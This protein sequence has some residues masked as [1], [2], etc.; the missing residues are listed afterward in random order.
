M[1]VAADR[2][3]HV[4]FVTTPLVRGIIRHPERL[5]L[6]ADRQE[7]LYP[8]VHLAFARKVAGHITS[9]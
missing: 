4:P 8:G 5:V 7:Y 1:L 2:D 3:G 9:R 6:L